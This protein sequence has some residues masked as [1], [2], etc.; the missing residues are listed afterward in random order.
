MIFTGDYGGRVGQGFFS[1]AVPTAVLAVSGI[2]PYRTRS[3]LAD[4]LK[5][6][7][8]ERHLS[9]TINP[10]NASVSPGQVFVIESKA[11]GPL[12]SLAPEDRP[13][14]AFYNDWLL[15]ASNSSA[16]KKILMRL[17]AKT[18]A[19]VV[20]KNTWFED[21]SGRKSS[22][23]ARIEPR[24][25]GRVLRFALSTSVF[26]LER[27]RQDKHGQA[28]VKILKAA[29]ALLEKTDYLS[30]CFLWLEPGQDQSVMHFELDRK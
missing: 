20:R 5:M 30:D 22:A 10:T 13:A 29:R 28:N 24:E 3:A 16:L 14:F 26:M 27:G 7:N 4:V 25:G 15:L 19:P 11:G 6:V 12:D 18:P 8:R 9:L 21:V 17:R 23:F 2:E 1:L